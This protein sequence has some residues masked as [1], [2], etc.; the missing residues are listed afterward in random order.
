MQNHENNANQASQNQLK[1]FFIEQ[2]RSLGAASVGQYKG[3]SIKILEAYYAPAF[4]TIDSHAHIQDVSIQK[5]KA[6]WSCVM[7]PHK[8]MNEGKVPSKVSKAYYLVICTYHAFQKCG[9]DPDN[10]LYNLL[11]QLSTNYTQQN[12]VQS[13]SMAFLEL[14]AL[15]NLPCLKVYLESQENPA[16]AA[17]EA[18]TAK[19]TLNPDYP[20]LVALVACKGK[21][22]GVTVTQVRVDAFKQIYELVK[23]R[24]DTQQ[25]KDMLYAEGPRDVPW[26]VAALSARDCKEEGVG[27]MFGVW[28]Y[29]AER[30]EWKAQYGY[31]K[32]QIRTALPA[33]ATL[34]CFNQPVRSAPA[35]TPEAN[36]SGRSPFSPVTL[37]GFGGGFYA[38]GRGSS[39]EKSPLM[40]SINHDEQQDQSGAGCCVIL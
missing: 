17:A 5:D 27:Q 31:V 9:K 29:F 4:A 3:E 25:R 6:F 22:P 7:F 35:V 18:I 15:S 28:S 20:S 16:C 23:N 12:L 33:C 38:A 40:G 10:D 24:F 19:L 21:S 26:I 39:T 11:C 14:M 34:P 13:M 1:D 32:K 8:W 37:G 36:A 30:E 2:L